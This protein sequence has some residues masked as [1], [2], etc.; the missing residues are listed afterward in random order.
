MFMLMFMSVFMSNVKGK[1]FFFVQSEKFSML[2]SHIVNVY[3]LRNVKNVHG[4]DPKVYVP[5]RC[6]V[7]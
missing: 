6:I 5:E 2:I 3:T 1:N 7:R 4:R